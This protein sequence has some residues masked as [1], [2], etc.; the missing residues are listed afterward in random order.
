MKV[1]IYLLMFAVMTG[2]MVWFRLGSFGDIS[3]TISMLFFLGFIIASSRYVIHE[4][5]FVVK[6]NSV[7][8]LGAA[9]FVV[10]AMISLFHV[11]SA[12]TLSD[13]FRLVVYAAL[14]LLVGGWLSKAKDEMVQKL[15][16]LAPATFF[17]TIMAFGYSTQAKGINAFQMLTSAVVQANPKIIEYSI[18]RSAFTA[19]VEEARANFR[20]DMA[21][22]L[23]VS[24]V[25]SLTLLK[26]EVAQ[27]R[28]FIVIL[29]IVA[30]AGFI[31]ISMSRSVSIALLFASLIILF[32]GVLGRKKIRPM[33]IFYGL[34]SFF[35]MAG[36]LQQFSGV[37]LARFLA[38]DQVQ[39]YSGR[40]EMISYGLSLIN[41]SVFSGT[42]F[43]GRED[44]MHNVI[45]QHWV[46]G[47]VI[48]GVSAILLLAVLFAQLIRVA[49]IVLAYK[50]Y[51]LD[52]I[53]SLPAIAGFV[54]LPLVRAL[55]AGAG[56]G[57]SDWIS[58]GMLI[59]FWSRVG[60]IRS[61]LPEANNEA[62]S[63]AGRPA[64]YR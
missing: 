33:W 38:E 31:L 43:D 52:C 51:N 3:P 4:V 63:F 55:T 8:V 57:A 58:I 46:G 2:P 44:S 16:W 6:K 25:V 24:I 56:L 49:R 36:V 9:L 27:V 35:L 50:K 42:A 11:P 48:A 29:G 41:E 39:S 26:R 12:Y 62:L 37:I 64:F 10:S 34:L 28:R 53:Y 20:H 7:L 19:G 15:V 1:R 30:S 13:I 61:G 22:A 32:L 54:A 45:L 23:L 17:L 21:G 5:V 18:F 60:R 14:G 47:G 59:G 40:A